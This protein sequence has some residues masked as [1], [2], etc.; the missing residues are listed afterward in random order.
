VLGALGP[1]GALPNDIFGFE[2]GGPPVRNILE[3]CKKY[4]NYELFGFEDII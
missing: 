3:I 4:I 1:L 2:D